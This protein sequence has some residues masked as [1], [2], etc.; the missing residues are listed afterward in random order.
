MLAP[1]MSTSWFVG[2]IQHS[3]GTARRTYRKPW[4]TT[5][6]SPW[7]RSGKPPAVERVQGALLCANKP[8]AR[9]V[10]PV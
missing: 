10:T 9:A 3:S 1:E 8:V 6:T 2:F 4:F 5:L 7:E